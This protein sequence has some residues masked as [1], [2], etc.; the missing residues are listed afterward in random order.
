MISTTLH[1]MTSFEHKRLTVIRV[2]LHYEPM[3]VD[4][5]LIKLGKF[6]QRVR[7]FYS[8]ILQRAFPVEQL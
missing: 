8:V 3:R 6:N 2:V 7:E 4:Y 5:L 1:A